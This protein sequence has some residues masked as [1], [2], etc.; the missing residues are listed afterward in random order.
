MISTY[1]SLH[2][3]K[4]QLANEVVWYDST[5]QEFYLVGG[6]CRVATETGRVGTAE[7]LHGRVAR[8]RIGL[9]CRNSSQLFVNGVVGADVLLRGITSFDLQGTDELSFHVTP[10]GQGICL[11]LSNLEIH[12]RKIR[13]VAETIDIRL[14]GHEFLGAEQQIG[15]EFPAADVSIAKPIDDCW[16]QCQ[17]CQDAWIE[18][19][20]VEFSRCPKC[21]K[22]TRIEF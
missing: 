22:L 13:F 7:T 16:R 6:T 1:Q 14:L 21:G 4:S 2:D 15:Y 8:I 12:D 20:R 18:S 9:S 19:P 5:I 10:V 3:I 17:D 11:D